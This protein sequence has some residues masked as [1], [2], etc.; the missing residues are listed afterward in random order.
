M[1]IQWLVNILGITVFAI[2]GVIVAGRAKMDP[3]G[4]LVLGIT[5]AIGGGTIRD[6]LLGAPVSWVV[7]SNDLVVAIIV[8]IS[9]I[10]ILQIPARIPKWG[11]PVLD[12]IGLAFFVGI[13]V[14]KALFYNA[15]VLVSVCMGVFTGVGGGIIRDT[16]A[17]EIPMIFRT[18]IYATACIA[19]AIV[20]IIAYK[21]QLLS[22][23]M[24]MMFGMSVT[25]A[26]RLLAIFFNLKLPSFSLRAS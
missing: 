15:N 3:I 1:H 25:L 19:G 2:S 4:V 9:A 12:A 10:F 21:Y 22:L 23:D 11:L 18:D 14:N 16:L 20:H 17:R 24:S 26:I 6:L 13:G 8:S 7:H 5:T